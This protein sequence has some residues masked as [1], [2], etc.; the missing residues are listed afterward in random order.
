MRSNN[1]TTAVYHDLAL[2]Y[3]RLAIQ[4]D[5]RASRPRND[6]TVLAF[7]QEE[8]RTPA[9]YTSFLQDQAHN[10]YWLLAIGYWAVALSD[11]TYWINWAEKRRPIYEEAIT[12]EQIRRLIQHELPRLL[13]VHHE[14][15]ALAKPIC[16]TIIASI[17]ERESS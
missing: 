7:S 9:V 15:W 2:V 5:V 8:H 10:D 4:K 13:R 16:Y 6:G 3:T 12:I 14:E 17:I 1:A 11:E